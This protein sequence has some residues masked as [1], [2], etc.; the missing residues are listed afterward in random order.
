MGAGI[1]GQIAQLRGFSRQQLFEMWQDL[2]KKAAPLG[3]R[4]ETMV[5][6]LADK[7]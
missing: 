3:I 1:A 6:F 4:R 2:Y 7:I 5:P